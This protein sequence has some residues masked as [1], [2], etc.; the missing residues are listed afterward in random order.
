MK[1]VKE[2]SFRNAMGASRWS[3]TPEG[4]DPGVSPQH[5]PNPQESER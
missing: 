2:M 5:F 1:P 4:R 3:T